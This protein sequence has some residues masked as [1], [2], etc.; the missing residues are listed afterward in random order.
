MAVKLNVL[1]VNLP[2]VGKNGEVVL[3]KTPKV[4]SVMFNHGQIA[5]ALD[6]QPFSAENTLIQALNHLDNSEVIYIAVDKQ[7]PSEALVS[8]FAQLSTL[9]IQVANLIVKS[10]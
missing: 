4:V 1:E 6:E 10:E 8:L 9:N 7:V 2:T 5:Y 3:E